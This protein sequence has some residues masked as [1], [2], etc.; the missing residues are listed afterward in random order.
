MIYFTSDLHLG[1]QN[2]IKFERTQFSSIQE[3]DEFII[4]TIK[5]KMKKND[6]LYLL[7]D[8]GN[9][10]KLEWLREVEW[11]KYFLIGNHD[12]ASKEY[13]KELFDEFYEYPHYL[14]KRI[15]L[16]HE[17]QLCDKDIL[18]IHG[19]LHNSHLDLANY[20][21]VNIHICNYELVPIKRI[22]EK[23]GSIPKDNNK[24]KFT[25]EW[26]INNQIFI[27]PDNHIMKDDGI[28]ID[29]EKE[30]ERIIKIKKNED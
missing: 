22:E 26:W 9:Q 27:N 13:Y 2:I 4:N 1:H 14:K 21:N 12:Y 7:G 24:Y 30:R 28:H 3:H 25:Y 18:N 11:K 6:E 23:L 5:K 15:L 17:P 10:N 19:H 8:I 20:F 16:S 29:V